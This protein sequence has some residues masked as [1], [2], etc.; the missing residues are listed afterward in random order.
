M[1][2]LSTLLVALFMVQTA[3]AE[4]IKDIPETRSVADKIIHLFQNGNFDKGVEYSRKY[5][6]M[7]T[8]ELERIA[9]QLNAQWVPMKE[10]YGEPVG[11]EFIK[12]SKLNDTFIRYY[13]LHKFQNHAAY[14]MI[15]FY[16]P[17]DKWKLNG[18]LFKTDPSVLF[19]DAK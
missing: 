3:S 4:G 7:P 15:T 12:A 18:I 8:L 1:R 6:S 19:V 16:K 11:V 9:N 17:V 5:W 2:I 13:Y 10:E 14:W